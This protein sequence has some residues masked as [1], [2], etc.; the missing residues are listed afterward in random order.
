MKHFL[1]ILFILFSAS[2]D[3]QLY[4]LQFGTN[5]PRQRSEWWING[6][7]DIPNDP[8]TR[9]VVAYARDSSYWNFLTKSFGVRYLTPEMNS[10]F[11]R[12]VLHSNDTGRLISSPIRLVLDSIERR[13]MDSATKRFFDKPTGSASQYLDGLGNPKAFP[14][15][16]TVKRM[17]TLSGN[18]DT[19]GEYTATYSPAFTTAPHVSVTDMS[20]QDRQKPVVLS[21]TASSI[22]IKIVRLSDLLG[23]IPTYAPVPNSPVSILI[24]ER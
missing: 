3:A 8:A 21:S 4:Y 24:V 17:V 16:P 13:N 1:S 2:A 5:V 9:Y 19:N 7:G 23:L 12:N 10:G 11:P 6:S 15:I 14:S 18:T 22:K 20:G